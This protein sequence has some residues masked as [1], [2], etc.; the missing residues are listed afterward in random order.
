MIFNSN[1]FNNQNKIVDIFDKL[2]TQVIDKNKFLAKIRFYSL[3]RFSIRVIV[4]L[5]IPLYFI[6]TKNNNEA[7]PP[8]KKFHSPKLI[9]SLTTFPARISRVWIVIE[10]LLRQTHKPDEIILWL[11]KDQFDSIDKL[12]KK[13]RK[14]QKNGLDIRLCSGD[15][16]SHKKYYYT[17]QQYPEDFLITV[18]DDIIYHTT[19]I[20]E[21]VELN[22]KYP[23]SIC[24]HRASYIKTKND[25]ILPYLDW[26]VI[27]SKQGPS[28]NIFQTSGGGTIYPPHSLHCE[29][30]NDKVFKQN[31]FYADD[32]WLNIMSQLNGT[33]VVKADYNSVLLPVINFNNVKLSSINVTLGKNDKQLDDV[34]NYY[35]EKLGVDAFANCLKGEFLRS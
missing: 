33:T 26:G 2:Y 14:Q 27:N 30:L 18:D 25:K 15:L 13:L 6:L 5:L 12:P 7:K 23:R 10:S 29:V 21:L 4:N 19:M 34:R 22:K 8:N 3:Q 1:L 28:Y 16:K 35:I 17:L 20:A 11:S 32:V 24:C 9:V 31:C